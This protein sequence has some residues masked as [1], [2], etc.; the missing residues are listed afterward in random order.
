MLHLPCF[1]WD[2]WVKSAEC[3]KNDP[4]VKFL[5]SPCNWPTHHRS[6]QGHIAQKGVSHMREHSIG[7]ET[8]IWLLLEPAGAGLVSL[9]CVGEEL[10]EAVCFLVCH[11]PLCCD[12]RAEIL[13]GVW[14]Q[15]FSCRSWGGGG[16][17]GCR[18]IRVCMGARGLCW[19]SGTGWRR[20]CWVPGDGAQLW[21]HWAVQKTK[22]KEMA[23]WNN[24][25]TPPDHNASNPVKICL[26]ILWYSF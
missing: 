3:T 19:G 23:I 12:C 26:F 17:W 15:L 21:E 2:L 22:R 20:M 1:L 9:S 16:F 5:S 14:M 7:G 18:S 11:V 6:P 4:F 25:K 24:R 13:E 8:R 10:T